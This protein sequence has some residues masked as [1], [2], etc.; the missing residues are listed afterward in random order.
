MLPIQCAGADDNCTPKPLLNPQKSV[1]AGAPGWTSVAAQP[2]CHT[3][4]AF[5]RLIA[6]GA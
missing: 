6:P 1:R 5:L 3:A 2:Y 4:V